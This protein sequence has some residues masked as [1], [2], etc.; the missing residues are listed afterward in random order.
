M[1]IILQIKDKMCT[2]WY[3]FTVDGV[4]YVL[5]LN[6]AWTGVMISAVGSSGQA[7]ADGHGQLTPSMLYRWQGTLMPVQ[8]REVDLL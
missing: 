6:A 1:F 2:S 7:P 3:S 4:T 5:L 8:V